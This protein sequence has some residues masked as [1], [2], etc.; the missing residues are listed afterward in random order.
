MHTILFI[1]FWEN[2]SD[3]SAGYYELYVP[4][5]SRS[6]WR[7]KPSPTA[8]VVSQFILWQPEPLEM[9]DHVSREIKLYVLKK[10]IFQNKD[11]LDPLTD[12]KT[13]P[14]LWHFHAETTSKYFFPTNNERN[15]FMFDQEKQLLP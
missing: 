12:W 2:F 4:R 13:V 3:L 1:H 11:I 9:L 8:C 5:T 14:F 10:Y 6:I 15:V 7:I